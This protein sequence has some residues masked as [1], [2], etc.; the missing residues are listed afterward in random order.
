MFFISKKIKE[1]LHN[2]SPST[3]LLFKMKRIGKDGKPINVYKIR[4][5]HPYAEYLQEFIYEKFNLQEG[6]K[7]KNDFRI[8]YLGGILRKLMLDELP[9][10]YNWLKG[11]LKLVGFRPLSLQYFNLYK[12]ELKQKRLKFKPGLIPPFYSDLPKTLDEIMESE[13]RYLTSYEK[14]PL[15]TDIR[16][17]IQCIYNIVFKGA[18]SY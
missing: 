5:M 8:T 17:F 9:M 13:E 6:G 3:G 18:R 10:L 16:Y 2:I 11:D 1:P 14:K 4:T 15:A 7:F 12:K